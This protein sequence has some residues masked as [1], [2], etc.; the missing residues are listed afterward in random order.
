MRR[1]VVPGEVRAWVA[2]G[3]WGPRRVR[4]SECLAALTAETVFECLLRDAPRTMRAGA[5]G[6]LSWRV[7]GRILSMQWE[8]RANNVWRPARPFLRCPLCARLVTRV[9]LPRADAAAGCRLCWGLTYESR[10]SNYR[11]VG[12]L[13]ELEMSSR[14]FAKRETAPNDRPPVTPRAGGPTIV[15]VCASLCSK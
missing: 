9:F 10:Q 5:R 8:L 1:F 3:R 14:D 7:S 12:P 13:R 6:E 2:A 4:T 15:A 11:N